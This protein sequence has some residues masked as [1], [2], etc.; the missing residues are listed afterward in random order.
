MKLVFLPSTVRDLAWMRTY[1][2]RVFPDGKKRA[3]TH[4]QRSKSVL[5]AN[6]R[7]GHSVPEFDEVR[8]FT[9]PN[10]PFSFML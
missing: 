7:I 3:A 1:Y 6:P 8:E 10:T 2:D 9:I 4:F 5:K